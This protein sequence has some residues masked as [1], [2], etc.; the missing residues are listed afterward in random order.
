MGWMICKSVSVD[1]RR[2]YLICGTYDD[3]MRYDSIVVCD[4]VN[5]IYGTYCIMFTILYR[6]KYV[7]NASYKGQN[8]N[9]L[10]DALCDHGEM[11]A[12]TFCI[13]LSV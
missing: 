11:D 8:K 7:G 12:T 2:I 13:G 10:S 9:S 6:F 1:G 5:R 3:T 4:T